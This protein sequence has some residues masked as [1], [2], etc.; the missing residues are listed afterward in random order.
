MIVT[1]HDIT[2]ANE[3][4]GEFEAAAKFASQ[5][6]SPWG[7]QTEITFQRMIRELKEATNHAV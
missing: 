4:I 6:E 5:F 7:V 2:F 3:L 1:T